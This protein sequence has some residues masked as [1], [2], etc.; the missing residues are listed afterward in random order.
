MHN[1]GILVAA[2]GNQQKKAANNFKAEHEDLITWQEILVGWLFAEPFYA[3]TQRNSRRSTELLESTANAMTI[4]AHVEPAITDMRR[5]TKN[6]PVLLL[7]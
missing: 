6:F 1:P 7:P 2:D 3:T 5:N 4:P